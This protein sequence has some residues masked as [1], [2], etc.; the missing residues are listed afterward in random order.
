MSSFDMTPAGLNPHSLVVTPDEGK[1]YVAVEQPAPQGVVR[2]VE[3]NETKGYPAHSI[4]G[5]NCP[6]GLAISPDGRK[7]YVASQCAS[8]QDPVFV[9]DTKTDKVVK[10]IAGFAVGTP[11][12]K[13][14][15]ECY[16]WL[17]QER[18]LHMT[19]LSGFLLE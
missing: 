8:G 10:A 16:I 12:G 13:K 7:L 4:D 18:R 6:E 17:P 11:K 14:S 1:L 15:L 19:G 9:I 5:V 2:I 3:L